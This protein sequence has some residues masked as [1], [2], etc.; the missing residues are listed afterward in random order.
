MKIIKL[1]YYGRLIAIIISLELCQQ[2]PMTE[3]FHLL[4]RNSLCVSKYSDRLMYYIICKAIF[5]AVF[6][7]PNGLISEFA[8]LLAL[9]FIVSSVVLAQLQRLWQRAP[10]TVRTALAKK[11]LTHIDAA[12]D[13]MD[14]LQQEF[15]VVE[16][17][18]L[19][20][21]RFI[22]LLDSS[23][24]HLSDVQHNPVNRLLDLVLNCEPCMK[25]ISGLRTDLCALL[26]E[27]G[28]VILF[29]KDHFNQQA[30]H[31]IKQ[32]SQIRSTANYIGNA[33]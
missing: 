1:E 17:S 6:G 31:I 5:G 18:Q 33:K 2:F 29:P 30:A 26:E 12:F 14:S 8:V 13:E 15:D 32:L 24:Q 23:H 3:N 9:V 19:K 4:Q 27:P 10:R 22:H 7:F 11:A 16:F 28:E 21:Q 20:L 25:D